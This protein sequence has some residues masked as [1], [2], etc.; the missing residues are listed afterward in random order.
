MEIK[1]AITKM[2]A[3]KAPGDDGITVEMLKWAPESLHTQVVSL[4][5]EIWQHTL[6]A[7]EYAE[8]D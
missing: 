5:Q 7:D 2:K 6:A 8:A 3:G 4:V 1:C